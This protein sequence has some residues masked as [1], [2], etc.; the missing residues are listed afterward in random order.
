MPNFHTGLTNS[1]SN[2]IPQQKSS[3]LPSCHSFLFLYCLHRRRLSATVEMFS[4]TNFSRL[5]DFVQYSYLSYHTCPSH[6]T[7]AQPASSCPFCWWPTS[8]Q[9]Q[10]QPLPQQ[11][12]LLE[13]THP[14]P[15]QP[16]PSSY[17]MPARPDCDSN[18]SSGQLFMSTPGQ[19]Q[20]EGARRRQVC[21]LQQ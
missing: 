7:P 19:V 6:T 10:H 21:H 14:G 1:S 4:S 5:L 3:K 2:T 15:P 12:P 16:P 13:A 11:D 18:S 17:P 8:H 20:I 9:S